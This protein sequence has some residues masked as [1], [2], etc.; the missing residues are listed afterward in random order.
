MSFLDKVTLP[1]QTIPLGQTKKKTGFLGGITF[2]TPQSLKEYEFKKYAIETGREAER[3]RGIGAAIREV[4]L[5]LKSI[6][7][8]T[9]TRI[10]EIGADLLNLKP[11]TTK[12]WG[13]V[14]QDTIGQITGAVRQE[15][16]R[17]KQA[18][19]ASKSP[20]VAKQISGGLE[21]ITGAANIVFSPISALFGAAE[22]IPVLGTLAKVVSTGFSALGDAG[23]ATFKQGV[24]LLPISQQ[25]KDVLKES[26]GEVGALAYQIIG[27]VKTAKSI[28]D[29]RAKYGEKEA[30][31]IIK[32]A[33]KKIDATPED[34][35]VQIKT[36]VEAK[37]E[38][39]SKVEKPIDY[40]VRAK[41]PLMAAEINGKRITTPLNKAER[42]FFY[43]E[44]ENLIQTEGKPI[45]HLDSG[46]E[47]TRIPPVSRAEFLKLYPEAQKSFDK[48]NQ[49]KPL[50][51]E[52]GRVVP[53]EISV[54]REQLPVGE[55]VEKVSRLEARV[56]ESLRKTSPEN[57]E[58]LG[59]TTY[60]EVSKTE[61]I[62]AASDYVIKNPTEALDV[63]RGAKE[64]PV[65]I[66][67]NSIY[68]AMEN[69]AVDNIALARKMASLSATR[70]GQELSIL[71][72]LN[73]DSPVRIMRDVVKINEAVVEK[74]TGKKIEQIQ[75]ETTQ[76]IKAEIKKNASKRPTWE[77]F[78]KEIMCNY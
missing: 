43:N 26:A 39:L 25:D 18:W 53:K 22:T 60:R 11:A 42:D 72:E 16:T 28:K 2:A 15:G 8:P 17:I 44:R 74:R 47:S 6:F 64:A 62:K 31:T 63:L 56:T 48:F 19:E 59:I 41:E 1:N 57:I 70:M 49:V 46:L 75:K 3:A 45:L 14:Y 68:V 13:D 52:V 7:A 78:I 21:V 54:P 51:Q 34:I 71:T 65:G 50:A 36:Q 35:K 30:N 76:E 67:K 73:P 20:S 23:T 4:P 27:G 5:T 69:A 37:G 12:T 33:Q 66:L 24:D 55:G 77:E 40:Q 29:L 61:N 9:I 58:R 38:F 10:K 32:E